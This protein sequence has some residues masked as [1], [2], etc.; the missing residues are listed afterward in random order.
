MERAQHGDRFAEIEDLYAGFEVYD[1]HGEKIG[2]VDDLF[3]D[4]N[5]R[6]EYIGVRPGSSG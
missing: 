1:R 5:D 2:K 3:V 4:E 6:P